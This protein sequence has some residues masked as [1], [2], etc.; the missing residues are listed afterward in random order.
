MWT[1][2]TPILSWPISSKSIFFLTTKMNNRNLLYHVRTLSFYF[3]LFLPRRWFLYKIF[4]HRHSFLI[5][6]SINLRLCVILFISCFALPFYLSQAIFMT[7]PSSFSLLAAFKDSFFFIILNVLFAWFSFSPLCPKFNLP[8]GV[9]C[10]WTKGY[11][12]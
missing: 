12:L 6:L 10:S 1:W 5:L 8:I 11:R 7:F 3:S 9:G 4:Q 2:I